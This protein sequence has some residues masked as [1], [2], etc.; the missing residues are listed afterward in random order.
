MI[1]QG[2]PWGSEFPEPELSPGF[3][4]RVLR[5]AAIERPRRARHHFFAMVGVCA[6]VS[7]VGTILVRELGD[8]ETLTRVHSA[9]SV[10]RASGIVTGKESSRAKTEIGIGTVDE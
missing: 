3:A 10:A 7:F 4:R 6:I 2:D 8:H 5:L 1:S 9:E